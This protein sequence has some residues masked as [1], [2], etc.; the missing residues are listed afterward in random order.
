ML[1]LT[2]LRGHGLGPLKK[3]LIAIF[4][5]VCALPAHAFCKMEYR[6]YAESFNEYQI[7]VTHQDASCRGAKRFLDAWEYKER[8]LSALQTCFV[9][10]GVTPPPF[11]SVA[12]AKD[13]ELTGNLRAAYNAQC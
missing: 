7:V 8:S 13:Y 4:L 2:N 11:N 6:N 12:K 10:N 9:L 5:P 3:V 1:V